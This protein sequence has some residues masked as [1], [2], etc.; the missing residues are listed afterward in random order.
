MKGA[1]KNTKSKATK[2]AMDQCK[3]GQCK[4]GEMPHMNGKGMGSAC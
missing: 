3:T 4:P 2:M 1:P